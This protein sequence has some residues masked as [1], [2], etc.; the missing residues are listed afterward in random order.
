M[1]SER[2]TDLSPLPFVFPLE[3]EEVEEQL[4]DQTAILNSIL[5]NMSEGV[6]V[7]NMQKEV[8]LTNR[9]A[10]TI[11]GPAPAAS[12]VNHWPERYGLFLP[13]GTTPLPPEQ[14]P[15]VRALA[16]HESDNVHILVR[17]PEEQ[18]DREPIWI[19][20]SARP[21]RDA[22]GTTYGAVSIFRT[23]TEIKGLKRH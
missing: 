17:Q 12:K 5:D 20:V 21:L 2:I 7:A 16:G 4:R 14:L 1:E 9:V 11:L 8:V 22:F 13:D 19:S 23:I 18:E 3:L 15:L 6:L 10:R